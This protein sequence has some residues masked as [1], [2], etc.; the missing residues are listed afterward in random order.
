MST[1]ASTSRTTLATAPEDTELTLLRSN[2]SPEMRRRLAALGLRKGAGVR[3]LQSTAGG[4]R[5][6][7]IGGIRIA[8]DRSTL[9]RLEAEV[10]GVGAN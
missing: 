4:G 9:E 8:L 2:G 6:V 1:T 7:G 5:V 3:I 10:V